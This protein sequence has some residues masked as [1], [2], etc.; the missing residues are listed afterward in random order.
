MEALPLVGLVIPGTVVVVFFGF[1]S[2]QGYLEI[3]DLIWFSTIGAVLGDGI[4][5]YLGGKGTRF[6]HDE[7][8][9]LKTSHL[10]WGE[11]FFKKHGNK[12]VLLGRF[13]GPLRPIIPF[14]AGLFR[15]DMKTFLFWNVA[16]GFLWSITFLLLGYFFGSALPAIKIWSTRMGVLLLILFAVV[17]LLRIAIGRRAPFRDE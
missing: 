8:K 16:S 9:F 14:V 1:L 7:N 11:A 10:V 2:A 5:Y 12:S 4:G 15:M 13:V 6:F 3:G 17:I